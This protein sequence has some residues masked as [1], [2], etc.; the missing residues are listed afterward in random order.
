MRRLSC[1]LAAV[2][3]W[4]CA[5]VPAPTILDA[6][7]RVEL[8][9]V[10][11]VAAGPAPSVDLA[12]IPA[13]KT[14]AAASAAGVSLGGC[15]AFLA[16]SCVVYPLGCAVAA[17]AMVVVCPVAAVVGG[18]VGAAKAD[19]AARVDAARARMQLL[20]DAPE[21]HKGLRDEV[22]RLARTQLAHRYTE[23]PRDAD[24]V[25]EVSIASVRTSASQMFNP[26][27]QLHV[28]ARA[29]AVRVS[30]NRVLFDN[31]AE[32]EGARYKLAEWMADGARP[33]QAEVER[34]HV[35]LARHIVEHNLQLFPFPHRQMSPAGLLGVPF[36]LQAEHPPTYGKL[37]PA[38]AGLVDLSFLI[39][40]KVDSA[41]PELR[42]ETFP[43]QRDLEAAP[44]EMARVKNVAYDVV[45]AREHDMAAA[46]VVYRRERIASN[47]HTLETA[48]QSARRYLWSVR[49]RF[50]LDGHQYVTEWAR[51]SYDGSNIVSPHRGSYRFA[52]P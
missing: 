5:S 21:V 52:T 50:E 1:L 3:A 27:L 17:A 34:A 6:Q 22:A 23:Q 46:E 37:T 49:A 8:G 30:D 12:G 16:P 44:A 11:V 29:R 24:T 25:L 32:F 26:P 39:W 41:Q 31:K 38:A 28:E 40:R 9:R 14:D 18:S 4:G 42:W 36:G 45:V 43:R 10:A 19:S 7:S 15:V 48:L 2:L 33:L 20:S 51:I 13:G 47:A 35:E